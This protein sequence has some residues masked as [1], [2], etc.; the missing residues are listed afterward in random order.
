[1]AGNGGE[2]GLF[3]PEPQL[4]VGTCRSRLKILDP[5]ALR[6]GCTSTAHFV[7]DRNLADSLIQIWKPHSVQTNR[8]QDQITHRGLK[9]AP[10]L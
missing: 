2:C 10:Q 6:V 1:M 7:S 8:K 9:N 4:N 5:K 3:A